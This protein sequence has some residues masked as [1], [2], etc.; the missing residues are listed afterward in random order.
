MRL[1]VW[2]LA[3]AAA[4]AAPSCMDMEGNEVA[5]WIGY[6]PAQSRAVL[7]TD[8]N[9]QSAV[10]PDWLG[11]GANESPMRNTLPSAQDIKSKTAF[12]AYGDECE[13]PT[14]KKEHR[15]LSKVE[16]GFELAHEKGFLI[17]DGRG[18]PEIPLGNL[19]WISHS[20]PH[21]TGKTRPTNCLDN[22]QHF[23]CVTFDHANGKE[24]LEVLEFIHI[25]DIFG[26]DEDYI[27]FLGDPLDRPREPA[28]GTIKRDI[29]TIAS[30]K[31]GAALKLRFAGCGPNC[32][33]G[34][35]NFA[36]PGVDNY[37][38]LRLNRA[39]CRLPERLAGSPRYSGVRFLL[40]TWDR[41]FNYRMLKMHKWA[42][43]DAQP[44]VDRAVNGEQRS[45]PSIPCR[46]GGDVHRGTVTTRGTENRT[47][48][49]KEALYAWGKRPKAGKPK[50]H[51][52]AATG[53][54]TALWLGKRV[55]HSKF[56][57]SDDDDGSVLCLFGTNHY[58]ARPGLGVSS[59]AACPQRCLLN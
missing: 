35:E 16:E 7:Y 58:A 27:S 13:K 47:P 51:A 31:S 17:Q 14:C 56:M 59:S 42:G 53:T 20:C 24:L 37:D 49:L 44:C 30:T 40:R 21:Y 3:A 12:M 55:D 43:P 29:S 36:P 45:F 19:V 38:G 23:F 1:F 6:Q 4:A 11:T 32:A 54:Q 26:F 8:S 15:R 2:L 18:R 41:D 22:A 52:G 5:W 9:A 46:V 10:V 33:R 39:H 48:N 28:K 25:Q 57:V 50:S 34:F